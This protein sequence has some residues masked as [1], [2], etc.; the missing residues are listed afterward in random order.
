MFGFGQMILWLSAW[1][2]V[3][4]KS[5]P[6]KEFG[7]PPMTKGLIKYHAECRISRRKM[8]MFRSIRLLSAARLLATIVRY[9]YP[10]LYGDVPQA[11]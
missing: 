8:S 5:T 1:T 11:G 10:H 3:R 4:S 6:S 9:F 2:L 7:L